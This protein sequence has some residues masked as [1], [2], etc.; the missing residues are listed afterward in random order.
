MAI[1]FPNDPN[2]GD[3]YTYDGYLWVY[4]STSTAWLAGPLPGG[5]TGATGPKG[6]DGSPGGATG[7]AGATGATGLAGATGSTGPQG[8]TGVGGIG[9]TGAQASA[10]VS[11]TKPTSPDVGDLWL[12]LEETGQLFTWDGNFWI[13]ASPG[14]AGIVGA[15]G[16]DSTVPGPPGATGPAGATGL[17]G[18]AGADSKVL[19]F[20]E[21]SSATGVVVHSYNSATSWY[22]TEPQSNFKIN[23]TDISTETLQVTVMTVY[24]EQQPYIAYVGDRVQINGLDYPVLWANGSSNVGTPGA[25]DVFEY[26]LLR[27]SSGWTVVADH[28]VSFANTSTVYVATYNAFTFSKAS[29]V[30]N[31]SF[32]EQYNATSNNAALTFPQASVVSNASFFEQYHEVIDSAIPFTFDSAPVVSNASFFEQYHEITTSTNTFEFP[33]AGIHSI[34]Y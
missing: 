26:R 12:D 21:Y 13:S 19:T 7:P 28:P 2:N 22:H 3:I 17:Q 5:A 10:T 4:N 27:R 20:R 23:F 15:T 30:S 9:A 31:K 32:F 14:G 8:A 11:S 29:V 24:I 34:D 18:P 6:D 1:S 25:I 33:Q 16:A